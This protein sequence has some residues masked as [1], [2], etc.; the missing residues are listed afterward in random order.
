MTDHIP[1][2]TLERFALDITLF[3]AEAKSQIRAHL[4]RCALCSEN[5]GRWRTLY[6]NVANSLQSPPSERDRA[7]ARK[8][9]GRRRLILP[10]RK[11]ELPAATEQAIDTYFETIELYRRPLAQ[12]IVRYVVRHPVRTASGFSI[13]LAAALALFFL[14]HPPADS[15]PYE[16][17]VLRSVL[18]VYNK[19]KQELWQKHVE[20]CEDDS[21][22][23]YLN[24]DGEWG[25]R[26]VQV[27]D[28]DGDGRN[29]VLVTGCLSGNISDG[30]LLCFESD[31]KLRWQ[32]SMGDSGIK[33]GALDF[34]LE[35][36]WQVGKF[37]TVRRTPRDKPQI[38][39]AVQISPSWPTKLVELDAATGNQK[40]EYWHAGG[41]GSMVS[42]DIDGD[43]VLELVI[44]GLNNTFNSACVI[45]FDPRVIRGAGPTAPGFEPQGTGP[46]TEKYYLLLPRSSVGVALSPRPYNNVKSMIV[47]DKGQVTLQ[48]EEC[49]IN[50]ESWI[51]GFVYSFTKEM[52]VSYVVANDPFVVSFQRAKRDGLISDTLDT[53]YYQRMKDAVRYWD[54]GKFVS[55][56]T[57]NSLYTPGK[58]KQETVYP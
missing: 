39:V 36:N 50:Q 1:E 34:T 44:G 48:T 46:G 38:F 40:Q 32:H 28:V 47:S 11:P 24:K 41:I 57:V 14:T 2:K 22:Q 17:K 30:S 35:P 8:L 31:G 21:L 56:V 29:E 19:E 52:A 6:E 45:V 13:T 4:D 54:G 42:A 26:Y 49:R 43:G 3:D 51:G 12:R 55:K 16:Y 58:E 27:V 25:R 37:L 10:F 5:L 23:T 53:A 20:S 7:L 33:F 15:N 18:H 9:A